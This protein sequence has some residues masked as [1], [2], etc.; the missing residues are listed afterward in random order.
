VLSSKLDLSCSI[1]GSFSLEREQ[2][3]VLG[4]KT[5]QGNLAD[6]LKRRHFSGDPICNGLFGKRGIAV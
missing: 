4:G 2:C 6:L 5:R 3:F 1:S